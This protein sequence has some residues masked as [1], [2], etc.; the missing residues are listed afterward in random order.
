M[1]SREFVSAL[2]CLARRSGLAGV[3]LVMIGEVCLP[4]NGQGFVPPPGANIRTVLSYGAIPNDGNDDT[5][6]FQA[7]LNDSV[8]RGV[9][10][11]VPD[12]VYNLSDRLNWGGVGSGAFFTMQGQSE[13]GTILK[14]ADNA[15]G[16]GDAAN[17]RVFI[18]AYEGNSANAFRNYLRDI[19]I[20]VGNGNPG[21]VGLQFQSNNTGRM[22]NVTIRSAG[23]GRVGHTGLNIGFEFPGPFFA[24]N[25]TIEG[26]KTGIVGAPQEYSVTF[27]N[28]TLRNQGELGIYVW[29][30]P[31][32]I[33]N[34][35]SI[36]TVPGISS[37]TNPGAWGHVVIDGGTLTGGS[38]MNDAIVNRNSA[39]VVVLRNVTT[40]GYRNAVRDESFS[41]TNPMTR[42]DGLVGQYATDAAASANPSPAAILDVAAE[43]TP[44]V[45]QY[46]VAQWASVAS[47]GAVANDNLDDTDAVQAAMSSGAPVVYFPS[48]SYY[49]SR[50]I[51]IGPS[52]QRIEGFQSDIII[53][54]PLASEGGGLFRIP[55]G[56]QAVVQFRGLNGAFQGPGASTGV[57]FD[58]A[59]ANTLV[60]RD[61]D[62]SYRNSVP[63][64]KVFLENVVG[65]NMTFTGQRVWAR[66]LNP[67]GGDPQIIND[68]GE[69]NVLGLKTEGAGTVLIA[70]N[71]ARTLILG[72]LI[73]P[74]TAI[75]NRDRP[76]IINEN[77]QL[78]FSLPESSYIPN[79]FYGVWV[80]ETRDGVTTDFTRAQVPLGRTHSVNGGMIGLYNGYQADATAPSVP[81]APG[82]TS[83]T[84]NSVAISWPASVDVQSGIARYSI[85]RNGMFYRAVMQ[86]AAPGF[87]DTLLADGTSYSYRISAVNGSGIESALGL[88]TSV[89]TVRD[90]TP[91]RVV[92]LKVGLDPRRVMLRFSERLDPGTAQDTRS[93]SLIGPAPAG[94]PVAVLAAALDA[95][96]SSVTLTT[97][98]MSPGTHTL[99]LAN[100]CDRATIPNPVAAG[101]VASLVYSNTADGTGLRG[102]YYNTANLTGPV[103]LTRVDSAVNFAYGLASPAPGVVNPDNFSVRWTGRLRPRF[104]ETYTLFVRSDDG[105]RLFVDGVLLVNNWADQG[106]TERSGSVTL[107]SSRTHDLVLEYYDSAG[108]AEVQ[109]SWQSPSQLKQVVPMSYLYPDARVRTVRT[110][111]GRGA[112]AQL[113]RYNTDENG[114]GQAT[115]AFHSPAAGGFHQAAIWRFDL[116]SLDLGN[117]HPVSA[118]ATLSQTYF[119]VGDGKRLINI[120][121]VRQSAGGDTWIES[122]P[123]HITYANAVGNDD[124]GG[125]ANPLAAQFVAT[126]FLDNTGFQLNNQPDKV[127]VGGERLLDFL[128]SDTDG[129]V[130]LLAKRVDAS[131]EGQ[132]WFTK[133]WAAAGQP[134][135]APGLK[136]ELVPKCPQLMTQP[137][138]PAIGAGQSVSL[139]ATVAGAPGVG[140]QWFRDGTVIVDGPQ[141][142]SAGGGLVSG[143]SGVIASGS[144]E[145][146]AALGIAGVRTS[147]AGVYSVVFTGGAG[148][149]PVS[150][151]GTTLIVAPAG[152]SIA[153][154]AGGGVD[155]RSPDGV[156]DGS[157]FISFINSFS[158]GDP[159]VDPLADVAG[160]GDSGLL[161]DGIIDGTDFI[162]FINAFSEGC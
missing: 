17:S 151:V 88:A 144:F 43:A 18:D 33:R 97:A 78:S 50:T 9:T 71:R 125:L 108:G 84:S 115:G 139:Y 83:V 30:L 24:Q 57:W 121:G 96:G 41:T 123:G 26:F 16:F 77:S 73:Y 154:V 152:C 67:E 38:V 11:Y 141:G 113:A 56:S 117:N 15:A 13:G 130:T 66:Q 44:T 63:G 95:E 118:V 106:P 101:S 87:T 40:N 145:G 138:A 134:G 34:L 81:P 143:A 59:T 98:P 54:A 22:E 42:A 21:V 103:V 3:A 129:L 110:L 2:Q 120:F 94:A 116:A 52:V 82:F 36:N 99:A 128:R 4:V 29:R 86:A 70:R 153:D 150:S 161:P 85:Y 25:I 79:G 5:A 104:D 35:V 76:M 23:P 114:A 1:R 47:F 55:P 69:L 136:V 46:P 10:L 159:L 80:R 74:A 37:D 61:G 28:L 126:Y 127:A 27:E 132:S 7:A 148:C 8:G 135:F 53:N 100:I 102:A 51:S 112:D 137:I 6:A 45:P 19:T 93:Y 107:D 65:S 157:D 119:G 111:D 131:N 155:G 91:P 62:I 64:G 48:G 14:L 158:T 105:T 133:E 90:A 58:H 39:G 142:A 124:S 32:Q 31:L 162:S 89:G 72:G 68:G 122:G 140:Y 12:G 92:G 109:F 147:D 146:V 60:V 49:I 149:A 156:V 20:D 160:G 75:D